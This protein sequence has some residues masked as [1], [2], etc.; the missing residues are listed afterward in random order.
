MLRSRCALE[1]E[2]WDEA[3]VEFRCPELVAEL[4]QRPGS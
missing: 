4:Q 1:G 2:E 3:E